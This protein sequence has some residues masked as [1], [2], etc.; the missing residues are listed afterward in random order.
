VGVRESA[1]Y[2]YFPSKEALFEALL[3]AD[4]AEKSEG[5][6]RVLDQPIG[7]P[8][9]RFRELTDAILDR[10]LQPRQQQLFRILMADG[11]RLAREGRINVVERMSSS[12][13]RL[14]Q[15]MQQLIDAGVLRTGDPEVMVMQFVGPLV[16][17]R[18]MHAMGAR[19]GAIRNRRVFARAHVDQFLDGAAAPP[20]A[21]ASRARRA[22][23]A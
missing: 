15:F 19:S 14:E 1:L 4:S 22:R 10:F 8:R 3:D 9:A 2:N 16:V 17:W 5:L 23:P 13:P 11:M 12:R 6:W 20:W 7:D 18:Q 21:G